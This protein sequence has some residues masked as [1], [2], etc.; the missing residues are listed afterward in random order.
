VW[1][2]TLHGNDVAAAKM[3]QLSTDLF[4]P[5]FNVKAEP[6][7]NNRNMGSETNHAPNRPNI[8]IFEKTK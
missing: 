8:A 3:S 5:R 6:R 2:I 7:N 4:I 1:R